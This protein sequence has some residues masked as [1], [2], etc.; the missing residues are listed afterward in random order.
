MA[1]N[2]VNIDLK[3]ATTGMDAG[4]EKS[5]KIKDNLVLI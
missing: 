4:V 2:T 1:G 3:L 5:Q